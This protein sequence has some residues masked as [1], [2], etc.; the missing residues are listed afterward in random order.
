LTATRGADASRRRPR[1]RGAL[2]ALAALL[3]FAF[4]GLCALGI[5]QVQRLHWK[6]DLI[7][8]VEARAHAEPVAAPGPERWSEV[9]A[10]RDE[11]R[12]VRLDGHFLPG[13]DTRVQALTRLGP[14]FWILSPFQTGGG[15]IV[16]VNRGFA[17]NDWPGDD[18]SDAPA[19]VTGLLRMSE[20]KGAFLRR[21]DPAAQRW[22]SRDAQAI[23]GA[24]GLGRVAPYFIDAEDI[25]GAETSGWPRAGLTVTQFSNNHLSYALTWF[26]L[27]LM[28]AGAGGYLAREESR[29][30][31]GLR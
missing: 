21:N 18:L 23:A 17:P 31:A 10:Q 1:G 29:S 22:Y 6:R 12:H 24:Q 8:R 14:G 3:S 15:A 19:Q 2:I 5:W 16:L 30:R 27:A 11:Y 4:A 20:P 13:H 25:P 7:E 26:A 9:S 28:V